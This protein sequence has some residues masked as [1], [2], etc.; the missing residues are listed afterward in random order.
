MTTSSVVFVR[1][2]QS[3]KYL[4]LTLDRKVSPTG[5]FQKLKSRWVPKLPNSFGLPSGD[6][7]PGMTPFC[8][9]CYAAGSEVSFGVRDLVMHNYR[10]LQRARTAEKMSVLL[11]EM[12]SRYKAEADRQKVPAHDRLFRIHWDG[13]FFSR[14]YAM[15]WALAIPQFPETRFW[16]YT[17]SFLAPVNVVDILT[18]ID[19][20]ALYLS[21][22][23]WNAEAARAVIAE[24]P[25]VLV[26]LCGHDY[27]SAR[28]LVPERTARVCPENSGDIAL[29]SPDT[30][31]G[32]N[33]NGRGACVAC[34]WC[35][36]GMHDILF[37]TSGKE[38]AEPQLAL[39]DN[40]L[41]GHCQNPEC[42]M[43][44]PSVPGKAR[45][46]RW[47]SPECRRVVQAMSGVGK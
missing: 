34:R 33:G 9:S 24:Y 30:I 6:S 10:L 14:E 29:M 18:G 32:T 31:E 5:W 43:P 42:Q 39:F 23:Q 8:G 15:A 46:K 40:Q 1:G 38:D 17:R 44:L 11:V 41:P 16:A 19:N 25:S 37:S 3:D 36:K 2:Q 21:V 22:D 20:L 28:E 12:L 13:D 27:R 35:V 45:P 26:A 7:C 47:C 4:K